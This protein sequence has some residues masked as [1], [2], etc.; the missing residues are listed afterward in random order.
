MPEELP[1]L[2]STGAIAHHLSGIS[3]AR[4]VLGVRFCPQGI[5]L[6]GAP[7]GNRTRVFAVKGRR[8]GPLDD[9]RGLIEESGS[10]GPARCYK[11]GCSRW[12][13]SAG[14]SDNSN[15]PE[16]AM[17]AIRIDQPGGPEVMRL[18]EVELPPL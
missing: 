12:Q 14:V 9:G 4:I 7:N 10:A 13:A 6:I 18:E 2:E 8:P 16:E 11:V 1:T 3:W 17:H 5:D 15:E